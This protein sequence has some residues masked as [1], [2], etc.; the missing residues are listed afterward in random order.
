MNA[1]AH[2]PR[3]LPWLTILALTAGIFALRGPSFGFQVWNVDEAIHAAVARTLLDGGVL[4]RDAIDQRTPLTYYAVAALFRI[5]GENNVW[6]MH[7]LAAALIAATS[8]GLL[9]LGRDWRGFGPGLAA[10]IL[11]AV[12]SSA[13]LPPGDAFAL[14]TEWFVA[15]FTT[16]AA[17]AF[18]RGARA[19]AGG[20]FG[21]AFL[22]KQ[23]ALL[24][25]GAPL[26][27]LFIGAW[28]SRTRPG[29]FLAD[30]WPLLGGFL[31]P[32]ALAAG[33]LAVHGALGD[34]LFYGWNYNLQYY[35]PEIGTNARVASAIEP[36]RLLG[37]HY[38]LTLLT[39]V[40]VA[41]W[42][43]TA[44]CDTTSAPPAAYCSWGRARWCRCVNWRWSCPSWCTACSICS[45]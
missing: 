1:P 2:F 5:A 22:S 31:V 36:F 39:T 9:L 8:A 20:L 15:C 42:A 18:H 28:T 16:W 14:N 30:L 27:V 11:F 23:P 45:S 38:P 25:V 41:A 44:R 33:Y 19:A 21:L 29:R 12:F 13:L 24:D 34:A 26:A 7:A 35:G 6:A 17:W 32:V 40:A 4:Y 43:A 37:T 3:W 10:A